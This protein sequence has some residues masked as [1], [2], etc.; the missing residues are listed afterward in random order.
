V[1]SEPFDGV[2]SASVQGEENFTDVAADS[3]G[4]T[5]SDYATYETPDFSSGQ[6]FGDV[7]NIAETNDDEYDDEMGY[8]DMEEGQYVDR[9]QGDQ[10]G[11]EFGGEYLSNLISDVGM[12]S[13]GGDSVAAGSAYSDD[14]KPFK[15]PASRVSG[16]YHQMQKTVSSPR[17]RRQNSTA[18]VAVGR[19]TGAGSKPVQPYRQM[20]PAVKKE[21]VGYGEAA[22]PPSHSRGI[23]ANEKSTVYTCSICGK[24]FRHTT[25]FQR[26]KQQ[27]EGVVFR[28]DLCGAVLCRRDVLNAHR[29]K[30][31]AKMMM[32]QSSTQP[33][34]SM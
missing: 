16:Y 27:H 17:G 21:E 5:A 2:V 33:F 20:K 4:Y 22:V 12:A 28:C 24:M 19:R 15:M 14:V 10:T 26:H 30:C 6:P 9:F 7:I 34:D 13:G 8:D 29:R 18:K 25:S 11:E 1:K 31:E 3:S 23:S 32:Q